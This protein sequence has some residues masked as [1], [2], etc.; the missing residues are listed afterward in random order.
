MKHFFVCFLLLSTFNVFAQRA[1]RYTVSGFVRDTLTTESLIN[2]S[3]YNNVNLAGTSTN[4][5]GFYSLTLPAGEV[6]LVYSY[7]G[8]NSQIVRFQLRRDTVIHMN[9]FG[10]V[11]LQE[12]EIVGSRTMSIQESTRMSMISVP[13]A[14]VKSL[15]SFG[16]E[17]DVFKALQLMPGIQSG[18]EGNSGLHV[19]GGSPDQNLILLDG[20]PLYSV[21]HLLGLF[22][23][24][25]GDAINSFEAYKGGFPARYGG[26]VSSVIDINLKEGNMQ[27]FH[28][29]GSIG[30]LSSSLTLE[31]PIVR[32]R[33]SFIVSGRRTYADL[34]MN[35][36]LNDLESDGFDGTLKKY[37]LNFYD[38][39]AKINHR[40]SDQDRIYLSAYY[41]NDNMLMDNELKS[42]YE[43][44]GPSGTG[45]D[46]MKAGLKS[47]N[48]MTTFRWNHVFHDRLFGNITVAYTRYHDEMTKKNNSERTYRVDDLNPPQTVTTKDFDKMQN[49][50]GIN[51]RIGR[52]AFDYIPSSNHYI[53]FGGDATYHTFNPGMVFFS[54]TTGNSS[55]G[56]SKRYAYEYSVYAEDDIRL[57]K[58]LQTNIGIH[59]SGYRMGEKFYS[60]FQPRVSARYLITPQLSAKASY[61]RMVQ[62][63][64]LIP[65]SFDGIKEFWVPT[66]ESLRPQQS[67]QIALGIAQNYRED[68]ELSL[69]G[70]YKTLTH[71]LDYKDGGSLLSLDEAWE[72]KILHGTGTSYGIELLAQKKTGS[73]TGWV[74]YMLS[75]TDRHFDELNGGMRFP[76]KYDRR[77]D[78]SIVFMKSFERITPKNRHKK[79]EFSATWIYGSG[80]CLTLPVGVIDMGNP[81][82]HGTNPYHTTQYYVYS[83]RNGYRMSPTHR[84][85]LG[86]TSVKQVKRGEIHWNVSIYNAYN[87]KNPLFVVAEKQYDGRF[88]FIQYSMLPFLPSFTFQYKF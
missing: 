26:R 28:G 74:G 31:G 47:G 62:F 81:I 59:W 48:F 79:Y 9:L 39:T 86:I 32:D 4:Q 30:T 23:L 44:G 6:E 84:L 7:V 29:E 87:R 42:K 73:F 19:R 52:I 69:E 60:I 66:T 2:A 34:L 76:Y 24:F 38:M 14:Q 43:D 12:V 41:G 33:T 11:N 18:S 88:K 10:S 77:H 75:W 80:H 17:K 64:H 61:A 15:P 53:R 78:L 21:S 40:F 85:D 72:Q 83:E 45:K 57:N 16:G 58:Y 46:R 37:N 5:Y 67:E 55:F 49:I 50:S 70:Y 56:A 63:I 27:T 8:Y 35:L 20:V 54:D 36:L 65:N 3:V 25:N 13:I 82:I 1:E 51:D 71:A 22:S 68:Y